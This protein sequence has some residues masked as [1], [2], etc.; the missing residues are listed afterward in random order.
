VGL[1]NEIAKERSGE[2]PVSDSIDAT[3][4]ERAERLYLG[5]GDEFQQRVAH[6]LGPPRASALREASGGW[7]WS[8]SV[9]S[10]CD[11]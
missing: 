4:Y 3:P 5:L 2:L 1:F 8:R 11:R 10:G 7:K 6:A 9:F